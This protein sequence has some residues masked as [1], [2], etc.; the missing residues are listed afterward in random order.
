MS[1]MLCEVRSSAIDSE[2]LIAAVFDAMR[3]AFLRDVS[4]ASAMRTRSA[5]AVS[6]SICDEEA[7]PE[8]SRIEANGPSSV[9][10]SVPNRV[11]SVDASRQS[12]ATSLLTL[13]SRFEMEGGMAAW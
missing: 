11:T 6:C 3:V 7:D 9:P 1:R 12:V 4:P 5:D 13:T 10:S 8:R 2:D